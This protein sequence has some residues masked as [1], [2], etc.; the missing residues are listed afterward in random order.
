MIIGAEF[1]RLAFFFRRLLIGLISR[2]IL[3]FNFSFNFFR[4][5]A[6]SWVAMGLFCL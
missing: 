4:P 1:C 3:F 2:A 5:Q 6:T